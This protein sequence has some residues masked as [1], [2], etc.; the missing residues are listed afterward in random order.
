VE[1][2]GLTRTGRIDPDQRHFAG[3]VRDLVEH[4]RRIAVS[5]GFIASADHDPLAACRIA[6][7]APGADAP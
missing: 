7:D 3:R 6:V 5:T 1:R 2:P 4:E